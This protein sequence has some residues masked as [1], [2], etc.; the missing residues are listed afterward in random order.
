MSPFNAKTGNDTAVMGLKYLT[1][2]CDPVVGLIRKLRKM[3][4]SIILVYYQLEVFQLLS[5]SNIQL[6]QVQQ[7]NVVN[8]LSPFGVC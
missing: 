1:R 4:L 3:N 5:I 7:N 2:D 8:V 6:M